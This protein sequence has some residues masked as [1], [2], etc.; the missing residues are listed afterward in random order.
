MLRPY[1]FGR[2]VK[3]DSAL[4]RLDIAKAVVLKRPQ[5][6]GS[7]P[8]PNPAPASSLEIDELPT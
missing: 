2:D 5:A 7:V 6:A 1:N 3:G 4:R 8:A